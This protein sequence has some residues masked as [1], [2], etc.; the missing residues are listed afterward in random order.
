LGTYPDAGFLSST[1]EKYPAFKS[2]EDRIH[3]QYGL[4]TS[5]TDIVV[6]AETCRATPSSKPYDTHI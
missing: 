4:N 3:I 1:S 2:F 6:R 5:N